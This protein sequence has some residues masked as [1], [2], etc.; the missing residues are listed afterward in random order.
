MTTKDFSQLLFLLDK[1]MD[2]I[3][4]KVINSTGKIY[5][6]E[7]VHILKQIKY[8]DTHKKKF[9]YNTLIKLFVP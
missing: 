3:H 7:H 6:P 5:Y 2:D 8:L 9:T 1:Y 4:F